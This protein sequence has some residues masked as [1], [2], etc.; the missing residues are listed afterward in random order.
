MQGRSRLLEKLENSVEEASS[1]S[2]SSSSVEESGLAGKLGPH[3]LF[4]ADIIRARS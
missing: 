4:C 3:F 2:W 1:S